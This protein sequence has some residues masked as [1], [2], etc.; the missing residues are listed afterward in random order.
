MAEKAR[1]NENRLLFRAPLFPTDYRTKNAFY[2]HFSQGLNLP[3]D[4]RRLKEPWAE[5]RRHRQDFPPA[6]PVLQQLLFR[7][8]PAGCLIDK[9]EQGHKSKESFF[10]VLL[11]EYVIYTVEAVSLQGKFFLD[12]SKQRALQWEQSY[13][14]WK[15]IRQQ[16]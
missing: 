1:S 2:Q 9:R 15:P 12:R 7:P 11:D 8:L 13:A 14:V 10:I 4:F 5:K 16:E 3:A 6:P